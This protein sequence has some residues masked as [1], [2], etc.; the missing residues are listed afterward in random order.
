MG[1]LD[2][3]E[4]MHVHQVKQSRYLGLFVDSK[5]GT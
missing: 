1:K 5:E 4:A 3:E 2:L